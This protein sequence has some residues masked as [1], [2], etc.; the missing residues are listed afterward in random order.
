MFVRL[1]PINVKT[2][3]RAQ[4]LCGT[5]YDP[6]EG[7]CTIRTKQKIPKKRWQFFFW[8]CAIQ[9]RE[10][11]QN[12]RMILNGRLLEQQLDANI[13]N[14]KDGAKCHRS[15]EFYIFTKQLNTSNLMYSLQI[16]FSIKISHVHNCTIW[17]TVYKYYSQ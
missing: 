14:R 12:S 15:L 5:S 7:F 17:C 3:H 10:N 2:A 4:S 6:R 11:R 1:Y 16:L 13:V 9:L 8:K